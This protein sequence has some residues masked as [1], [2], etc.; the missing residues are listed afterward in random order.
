MC[1]RIACHKVWVSWLRRD[2]SLG[3]E[4]IINCTF[5]WYQ[6][7]HAPKQILLAETPPDMD[8]GLD[9]GSDIVKVKRTRMMG[10]LGSCLRI[11]QRVKSTIQG[12]YCRSD[13]VWAMYRPL[14]SYLG[15]PVLPVI[16]PSGVVLLT[17]HILL[18]FQPGLFCLSTPQAGTAIV[19]N[20]EKI[21]CFIHMVWLFYLCLSG[22]VPN[23][24]TP[25]WD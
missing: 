12:R 2:L 1:E 14:K 20:L 7:A 22:Q 24:I 9:A 8:P 6:S 25:G 4:H 23:N 3:S 17:Q 21:V 15:T 13:F 5:C 11:T 19:R 10:Q 16:A 18:S